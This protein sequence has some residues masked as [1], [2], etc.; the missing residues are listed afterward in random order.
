M[1]KIKF[2]EMRYVMVTLEWMSAHGLLGIPSMRTSRDGG[3]VLLHYE[4]V[5]HMDLS[6]VPVYT[7]G[8]PEFDEVMKSEE[9]TWDG[10]SEYNADFVHVAAVLNLVTVTRG[11][12]Q[13]Y[14]LSDNESLKVRCM[15]PQ[16]NT[17]IGSSLSAGMK[18]QYID[19]LYKVRQDIPVVL[20][21]Q[22][23]GIATMALYEMVVETHEGTSDDPIP[24]APPMEIYKNKY[25]IQ[26]NITYFCIRGSGQAL[27]HDL[28]ALVGIYV[29]V[30]K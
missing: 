19:D 10:S 24:Y 12:M 9:W 25:Y 29:E 30:G 14:N 21:N 1:D 26:D 4:L 20:E 15:Y 8:T 27:A 18:V 22:Y 2:N 11:L 13:T 5:R 17:Y 23:P 6:G 28:S 3:M 16:W 7:A